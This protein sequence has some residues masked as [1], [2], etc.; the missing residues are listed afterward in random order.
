MVCIGARHLGPLHAVREYVREGVQRPLLELRITY[1]TYRVTAAFGTM[2][3][4][5]RF[6]TAGA[7]QCPV[8]IGTACRPRYMKVV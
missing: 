2:V 3:R 7:W 4:H 1:A 6:R 5:D 8:R